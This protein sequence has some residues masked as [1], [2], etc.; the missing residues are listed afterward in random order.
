VPQVEINTSHDVEV[1]T[2]PVIEGSYEL[3]QDP[4]IKVEVKSLINE[5]VKID[6]GNMLFR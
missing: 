1:E 6:N 2:L 4:E 3:F 5:K